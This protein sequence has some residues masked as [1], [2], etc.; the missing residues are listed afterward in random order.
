MSWKFRTHTRNSAPDYSIVFATLFLVVFGLVM[1]ASASSEL[2]QKKFGDSYFYLKHQMYYGL[3]L[4]LVGF[5][6]ASKISY[7]Y[8][9]KFSVIFLLASVAALILVFTPLGVSS[10]GADR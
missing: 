9:Q 8:Y 4:G 2:G 3:S 10:G 5:L 6:A 1:V 7:K